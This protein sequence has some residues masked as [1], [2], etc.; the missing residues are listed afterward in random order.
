MNGDSDLTQEEPALARR[1]GINLV[2]GVPQNCFA[3]RNS[4]CPA[5]FMFL[6]GVAYSGIVSL[7]C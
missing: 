6:A 4:G 7:S 5:V 3:E 2:D 1:L